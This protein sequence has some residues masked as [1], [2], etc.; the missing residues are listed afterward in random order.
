MTTG[1]PTSGSSLTL[2]QQ[3]YAG[4]VHT[5]AEDS[6]RFGGP[7]TLRDGRQV[8]LRPIH[9][10]D[11]KR[12]CAMHARLSAETVYLR[13]C[14]VRKALSEP[15]AEKLVRA[16]GA[17]RMAVVATA[18]GAD[19]E[20]II[21][22]AEYEVTAPSSAEVAFVVEDDWQGLGIGT[23]LLYA[24]ADC[25]HKHEIVRFI[26]S[27]MPRNEPMLG[28]FRNCGFPY[29]EYGNGCECV[30]VHLDLSLPPAAWYTDT[31]R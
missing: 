1:S 4:C 6:L 3:H 21:A 13:Y 18:P 19:D 5:L 14:G 31:A 15:E 12:L 8:Y 28:V 29:A 26:A 10:T 22:V 9:V 17:R 30:E 11:G 25:A 16:D 27:V 24:L 2:P 7:V 20:Q 23:Q